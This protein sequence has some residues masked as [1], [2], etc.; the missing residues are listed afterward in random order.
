M[1]REKIKEIINNNLL[2]I[3]DEIVFDFEDYVLLRI[4]KELLDYTVY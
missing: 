4:D 3:Q 1:K 2:G